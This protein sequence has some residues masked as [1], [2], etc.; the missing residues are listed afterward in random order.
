M[1]AHPT[2]GGTTSVEKLPNA[3]DVPP[4]RRKFQILAVHVGYT[5]EEREVTAWECSAVEE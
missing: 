2:P 3:R 5:A 1:R 4:C